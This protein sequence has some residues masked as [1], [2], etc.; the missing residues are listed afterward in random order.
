MKYN[1]YNEKLEGD[2]YVW[3]LYDNNISGLAHFILGVIIDVIL[4]NLPD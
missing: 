3:L 1:H 2:L 4:S